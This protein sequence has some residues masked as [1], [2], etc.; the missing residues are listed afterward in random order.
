[1]QTDFD[2]FKEF[3]DKVGIKYEVNVDV[4]EIDKC[5]YEKLD[6]L[7]VFFY[8]DDFQFQD[9]MYYPYT[10]GELPTPTP[11]YYKGIKTLFVQ[12]L[13]TCLILF[14][15]NGDTIIFDNFHADGLNGCKVVF[16][17]DDCLKY[18]TMDKAED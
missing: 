13:K 2:L 17:G 8:A 4:L 6:D 5:H 18:F 12:L 16:D 3:F 1:M 11:L 9:F 15:E 7:A 14:K 10:D